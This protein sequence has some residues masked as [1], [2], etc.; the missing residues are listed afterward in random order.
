LAFLKGKKLYA[1]AKQ[2]RSISEPNHEKACRG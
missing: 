1:P 2:N